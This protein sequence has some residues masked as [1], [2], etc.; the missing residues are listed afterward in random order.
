MASK[1]EES[2]KNV[3]EEVKNLEVQAQ[4]YIENLTSAESVVCQ[5][6]FGTAAVKKDIDK[7]H[8]IQLYMFLTQVIK[9]GDIIDFA[10]PGVEMKSRDDMCNHFVDKVWPL[11]PNFLKHEHY[12]T[13]SILLDN[14]KNET[15]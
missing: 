8:L 5:F 9:Q 4:G 2:K 11:L 6:P 13:K 1:F 7:E 12:P 3:E 14:C 15:A 10:F